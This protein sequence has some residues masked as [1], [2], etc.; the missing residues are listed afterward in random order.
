M[1]ENDLET[2]LG[3]DRVVTLDTNDS[4]A[5]LSPLEDLK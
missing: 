2:V 5:A 4:E 3:R 1:T